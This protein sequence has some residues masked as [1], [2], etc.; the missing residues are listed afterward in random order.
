[1]T[2]ENFVFDNIALSDLGYIIIHD[3]VQ[4]EDGVVSGMEYTTVKAARS[5]LSHKVAT[6]YSENYHVDIEIMKNPCSDGDLN[7]TNDVISEMARWLCR[8]E[9]KWFRWVDEIGQD[10]IWHEVRITMDKKAYGTD[11]IGLV[12]HVESN[13]PY[14]LTRE[15]KQTWTNNSEPH[16]VYVRTDEEGYIYPDVVITKQGGGTVRI[17]NAYENRETEIQNCID[18]EVITIIGGDT[19]QITSTNTTHDFASDF[20]YQ[21]PRLCNQYG[22]Y[23]NVFT[24]EGDCTIT[25]SYR[26]IRKV[27]L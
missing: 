1:M 26:G 4:D 15:I 19:K 3:G 22:D 23:K 6:P 25:L 24:V 7:L 14:G 16:T 18:G 21:F 11:I 10:E 12:L 27:G 17:T 20:N 8:K 5:D 13:R 2:E 9:Y